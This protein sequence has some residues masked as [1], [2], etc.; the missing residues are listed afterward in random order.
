VLLRV[1][2]LSLGELAG[3][4]GGCGAGDDELEKRRRSQRPVFR[5]SSDA[6]ESLLTDDCAL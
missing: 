5:S 4:G 6:D 1:N 3:A 2:A